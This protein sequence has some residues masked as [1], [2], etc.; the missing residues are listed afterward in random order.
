MTF[1]LSTNGSFFRVLSKTEYGRGCHVT[2]IKGGRSSQV[3]I[4]NLSQVGQSLAIDK[5]NYYLRHFQSQNMF[6]QDTFTWMSHVR[7]NTSNIKCVNLRC[8]RCII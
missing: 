6:C 1:F 3:V 8:Y 5:K 2:K 4:H 7:E